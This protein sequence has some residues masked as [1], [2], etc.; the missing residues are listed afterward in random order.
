[1]ELPRPS[2]GPRLCTSYLILVPYVGL[3]KSVKVSKNTKAE[4][5]TSNCFNGANIYVHRTSVS[6]QVGNTLVFYMSGVDKA[7]NRR[8]EFSKG[9]IVDGV[10][11]FFFNQAPQTFNKIELRGVSRQVQQLNIQRRRTGLNQITFLVTGII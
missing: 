10:E 5:T 2:L 3:K 7:I 9:G 4:L 11:A 8:F 1:V 6:R